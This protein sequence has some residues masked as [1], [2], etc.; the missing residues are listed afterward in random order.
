MSEK[1][2][3]FVHSLQYLP[4]IIK[5][6]QQVDPQFA[7]QSSRMPENAKYTS[8]EIQNELLHIMACHIRRSICYEATEAGYVAIVVDDRKNVSCKEQMNFCM[9]R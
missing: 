4:P 1:W 7:V 9:I 6:V 5:L 8:P 3:F 2:Q